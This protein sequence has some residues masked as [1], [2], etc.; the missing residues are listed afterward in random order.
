MTCW[1]RILS[2]TAAMLMV[3]GTPGVVAAAEVCWYDFNQQRQ[4]CEVTTDPGGPQTTV[5][6]GGSGAFPLEWSRSIAGGGP[7]GGT[8]YYEE[9]VD[10]VLRQVSGVMWHWWVTNSETG[11]IVDQGWDCEWPGEDPPP[12][13]TPPPDPAEFID[14]ISE[15]LTVA[16]DMSPPAVFE[17]ITGVDTWFWCDPSEPVSTEPITIGGWTVQAT[18]APL[19]YNW[20]VHNGPGGGGAHSTTDCGLEPLTDSDGEGSA[21]M[22]QPQTKGEYV[23]DFSATWAGTWTL[24]YAG[25]TLGTFPLG[26]AD[27]AAEP[28]TYTVDEYVGIL[29][30]GGDR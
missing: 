22:W 2:L 28:I 26:P 20:V 8:C 25:T 5:P 7:L 6:L 13:P 10:G 16:F 21:W 14:S 15:R 30:S 23:V 17:G 24:A 1:R 9:V 27:I 3:V 19:L 12:P 4:V 29:V 18:M 11:D